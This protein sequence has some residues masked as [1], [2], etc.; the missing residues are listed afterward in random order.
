MAQSKPF[1]LDDLQ[2]RMKG[3]I[4]TLKHEFAGLRTGRASVSL[5][6]PVQVDAYGSA[7]PLT[8]PKGGPLEN[9]NAESDYTWQRA[10]GSPYELPKWK[11]NVQDALGSPGVNEVMTAANFLAPRPGAMML[12]K[13]PEKPQ[14]IRAYHGSPHD[15]DRFDLGKIGTGEG[16]QVY[17][18]GLYFSENEGVARTYRDSRKDY[19]INGRYP[20]LKK[21]DHAMAT[22]L[23]EHGAADR[24]ARMLEMGEQPRVKLDNPG[25]MYEVNINANPE[26][27]LDWDK[28][29]SGQSEV[30]R[31]AITASP[32]A[33]AANPTMLGMNAS[34]AVTALEAAAANASGRV[35]TARASVANDLKSRGVAGV[36]YDD[37]G[38]RGAAGAARTRNHVVFDEN[39]ISILRK[40]GLAGL[41]AGGVASQSDPQQ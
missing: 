7:M 3:A 33:K 34:H 22:A 25:H 19:T 28:P 11:Q 39:L 2:K 16:A 27:F 38:S 18:H 1:D 15:F 8:Q 32:F 36:S 31:N 35:S 41:M 5:L 4:A 9:P 20:D 21:M 13:M 10:P 26:H 40:Y 29:M 23:Y 12:P 6:E 14:G 17:G 24:A 37:A 30:V